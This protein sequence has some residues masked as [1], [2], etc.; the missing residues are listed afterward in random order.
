M[1][2][3][4]QKGKEE[5]IFWDTGKVVFLTWVVVP[6]AYTHIKVH[7]AIHFRLMH[8]TH[9]F[10]H[11]LSGSVVW[12]FGAPRTVDCQA[13]LP[14]E[15]SRQEYWSRLPFPTLGNLPYSRESSRPWVQTRIPY[16]SCIGRWILYHY[17]HLG[18]PMLYLKNKIQYFQSSALPGHIFKA[19]DVSILRML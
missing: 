1:I 15:C 2:K 8:C 18:S 17:H 16:V 11:V 19:P 4:D 10:M 7:R 5:E 12:L 13:P 9:Y 6:W 14:I 3:T